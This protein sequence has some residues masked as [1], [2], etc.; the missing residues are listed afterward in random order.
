ML[1][2]GIAMKRI[3]ALLFALFI[4]LPW[5]DAS[6]A[7]WELM[8]ENDTM[9]L[10]F[11]ADS[12]TYQMEE[13]TVEKK[14][15]DKKSDRKDKK[16]KK[17]KKEAKKKLMPNRD[18]VT[19]WT[20]WDFKTAERRRLAKSEDE[21]E[22]ARADIA[23]MVELHFINMKDNTILRS[24]TVT[25]DELGQPNHDGLTISGSKLTKAEP[26]T[27]G[28]V[29]LAKVAQFCKKQDKKII[30]RSIE[31]KSHENEYLEE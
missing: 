21:A 19:L 31:E 15:K 16:G 30:K 4:I 17:D 8:Y 24:M 7:K 2:G 1:T 27:L 22:Q 9:Q 28:A 14:D 18:M 3:A 6:A 11:D 23:E 13:Q 29:E 26:G 12:V 25:Y 10:Y 5:S 20:K